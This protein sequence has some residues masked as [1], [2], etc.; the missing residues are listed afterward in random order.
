LYAL[1]YGTIPI[2]RSVGGLKDSV[3]SFD[4]LTQQGDGIIFQQFTK[5]ALHNALIDA[6]SLYN[7]SSMMQSII[8]NAM[9]ADYSIEKTAEE[10]IDE[11]KKLLN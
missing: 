11:F 2:V 8:D 7:D 9:Q 3:Q 4:S 6:L 10:Y 1:K 5:Q